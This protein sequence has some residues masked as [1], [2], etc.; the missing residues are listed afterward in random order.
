MSQ[1]LRYLGIFKIKLLKNFRGGLDWG[2]ELV[3]YCIFD[4]QL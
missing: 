2:Y 4:I 3:T 1:F